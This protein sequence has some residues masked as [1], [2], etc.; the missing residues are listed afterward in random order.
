MALYNEILVGRYARAVQKIFGMKGGAPVKQL[1][2]DLTLVGLIESFLVAENRYLVG[3]N[4][5]GYSQV[6]TASVGNTSQHLLRNLAGSNVIAV[7]EKLQVDTTVADAPFINLFPV[8]ANLSTVVSVGNFF[9]FDPRG[10]GSVLVASKQA[11]AA[12]PASAILQYHSAANVTTDIVLEIDMEL[13]ILPGFGL[14]I[15]AATTNTQLLVNIWWRER[16]LE[17]SERT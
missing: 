14:Q 6:Q 7:V 9:G 10:S 13:P 4:R 5:F 2:G 12:G 11:G 16:F 3:Y 17:E 8:S 15:S 1:A